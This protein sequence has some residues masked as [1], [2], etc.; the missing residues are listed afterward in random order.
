MRK[1]KNFIMPT[2]I[3]SILVGI[4]FSIFMSSKPIDWRWFLYIMA[5]GFT[6]VWVVYAIILFAY[7][8]LFEGRRNR[9]KLKTRKEGDPFSPHSTKEWEDLWEVT[10]K[11]NKS[12][13]NGNPQWN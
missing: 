10:S 7:V 5:L 9:N 3:V 1:Q 12:L 2:L 4:I 8:F 6:L 11:G 13:G